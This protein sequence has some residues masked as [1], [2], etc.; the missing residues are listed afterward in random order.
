MPTLEAFF[1]AAKAVVTLGSKANAANRQ[2]I[3]QV[4]GTLADELD[5]ALLLADSYLAGGAFVRD[6]A[7]LEDYLIQA[8][9]K[10][11]Q[12]FSEHKVCSALYQLADEFR[13]VFNAKKLSVSVS[14][15]G[16]VPAL[17]DCLKDGERAVID[18]LDSIMSEL[19]RLA[20]ETGSSSSRQLPALRREVA[21]A[22]ASGRAEIAALRKRIK[23]LR[24]Q[25]TDKL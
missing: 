10:I 22:L 20:V 24:R 6:K 19:S 7:E 9:P 16:E 18:S 4:V 12:D 13:Q 21:A 11:M 14:S 23:S 15:L 5:R 8:Y 1:S 2:E 25:V 17:I 3:R